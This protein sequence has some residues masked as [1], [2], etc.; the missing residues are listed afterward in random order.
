MGRTGDVWAHTA[1]GITPDIMTLAKPLASGLPIGAILV[2]QFIADHLK[3]G[4]H[5]STFAGGPF[6]TNIACHVLERISQ[7][8][9]LGHVQ[10]V[11][12]YLTERLEELNSPHIVEV[13]GRGLMVGLELDADVSSLITKGY[14]EG[15][16]LVNAGTNVI[17]LVPPLIIQKSDVDNL[18]EKLTTLLEGFNA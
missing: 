18:V 14:E 13:R 2:K 12:S 17:R 8:E 16:L 1:S 3:P 7:P 11:G 9:F 15:L 10:E 5:G 4:D 6:V